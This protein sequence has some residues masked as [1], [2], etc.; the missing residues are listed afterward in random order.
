MMAVDPHTAREE[1]RVARGRPIISAHTEGPRM[2][3]RGGV[4]WAVGLA[5]PLPD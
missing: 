5:K 2:A 4:A 1:K 3:S